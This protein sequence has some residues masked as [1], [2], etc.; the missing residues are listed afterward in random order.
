M[1][2]S[3]NSLLATDKYNPTIL[4]KLEA[5]I[6]LQKTGKEAYNFAVNKTMLKHYQFFPDTIKT[7]LVND[8]LVLAF[9]NSTAD[10][11]A[12]SHVN[13]LSSPDSGVIVTL[14]GLLESCA[15]TQFWDLCKTEQELIK[16]FATFNKSVQ[17][18]ILSTLSL[19][20]Q[21]APVKT[22]AAAL[23]MTESE[24]GSLKSTEIE[25]VAA[26]NVV[27]KPNGLNGPR[28]TVQKHSI[29]AKSLS[30]VL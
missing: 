15:Y 14:A 8:A 24:V 1:V 30:S 29:S 7:N 12:L 18:I 22:V 3:I 11:L 5:H 20:F 23:S 17:A 25:S 21:T 4:P 26:G 6:A 9:A 27:F 13:D 28:E 16:P 10:F 2:D 19:A